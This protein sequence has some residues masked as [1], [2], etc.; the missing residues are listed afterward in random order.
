MPQ[1]MR[2][3]AFFFGE[4]DNADGRGGVSWKWMVETWAR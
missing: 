1:E 4:S 3:R 2:Q